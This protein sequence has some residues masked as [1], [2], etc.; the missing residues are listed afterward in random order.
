M[1]EVV[2]PDERGQI[3]SQLDLS[4][5][6]R[7][8]LLDFIDLRFPKA[9]LSVSCVKIDSEFTTKTLSERAIC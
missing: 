8:Y 4:V 2:T 1:I 9:I 6:R 7:Y 3:M 5:Y